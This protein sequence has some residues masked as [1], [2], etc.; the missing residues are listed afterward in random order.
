MKLKKALLALSLFFSLVGYSS[1]TTAL[2]SGDWMEPAIWSNGVPGCYDTIIIPP[3]IQVDV[4]VTI[5]LTGCPD[6]MLVYVYGRIE[7]QNG[8]K[9]KFPCNTDVLVMTGGSIGVGSGG[10]SSTYI[11]ICSTT[12]WSADSG[13]LNGPQSLCDGGC[14]PSQL[15]V[16]LLFFEA[17]LNESERKVDL[18]WATQTELDN[19]YFT[20]QRSTDGLTWKDIMEVDGAGNSF[21][22]IDYYEVDSDPAMGKSYYR[23][24]QTDFNGD[25]NYS[26][27]VGIEQWT[28]SDIGLYPN[29]VLNGNSIVMLFP[30]SFKNNVDLTIY[31]ADGRLVYAMNYD[32][33]GVN[34][35]MLDIDENFTAG[36][37][38]IRANSQVVRLIV[39]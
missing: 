33:T 24:K 37:Y 16:E 25:I 34:Q 22:R 32:L 3:N 17:I 9:L 4:T 30:E 36:V 21:S 10:G 6:S 27:V 26:A 38:T 19:D 5:D 14:P 13:D 11:E 39:E 28:G 31:S 1:T 35:I 8:K 23:L 20:V 7:F 2:F 15:P 29:P 12:Y 18:H